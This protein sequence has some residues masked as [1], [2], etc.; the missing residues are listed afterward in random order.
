MTFKELRIDKRIFKAITEMGFETPMP[1]QEEVIPF[2][3]QE[4]RDL[5]ALAHTGTGKTAAFGIPII[6]KIDPSSSKTQALILAPTRELC[7]Q[8]TDDLNHFAKHIDGLNIVP[9]YGGASIY[10]P[11]QADCRRR[12]DRRGH[13][14]P[15]ARHA[16]AQK[17]KC[18]RHQLAGA[19]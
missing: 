7:L 4:T 14:R 17:G 15:N 1:V 16:E 3:L 6:Q 10:H 13:A 5:V 12:A 19:G 8:I 11:D 9:I 18:F 2:L